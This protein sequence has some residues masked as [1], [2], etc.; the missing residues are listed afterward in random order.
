MR[1]CLMKLHL[2]QIKG[3]P[4]DFIEKETK[5]FTFSVS[6]QNLDSNT[7]AKLISLSQA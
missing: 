6:H 5:L 2:K 3:A 7:H 1:K 4:W